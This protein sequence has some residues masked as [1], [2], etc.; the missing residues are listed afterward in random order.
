MAARWPGVVWAALVLAALGAFWLW[1]GGHGPPLTP[2]EGR[3][4]LARA[5]ALQGQAGL[6]LRSDDRIARLQALIDTDDGGEFWMVNLETRRHDPAADRAD[7]AYAAVVIPQL[8]KRGSFPVYVGRVAGPVLGEARGVNRVAIV[9][10]R[11]LRD[12]L[13]MNVDPAFVRGVGDKFAALE[14]TDVLMTRPVVSALHVRLTAV[15]PAALA[16]IA[17]L[18]ILGRR[19]RKAQAAGPG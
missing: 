16:L 1:Y 5:Q 14:D 6:P 7:A 13:A 3:L 12:F 11:S 18:A 8:L 9:R 15:T 19:A 10:Y 4:L 2:E 17:G